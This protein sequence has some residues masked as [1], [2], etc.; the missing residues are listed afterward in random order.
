M[1]APKPVQA[2][3]DKADD[4]LESEEEELERQEARMMEA[5]AGGAAPSAAADMTAVENLAQMKRS[6]KKIFEEDEE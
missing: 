3:L 6:S 2:M 1:A 5:P 4:V